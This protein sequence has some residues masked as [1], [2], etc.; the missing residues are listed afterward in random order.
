MKPM[1]RAH[2]KDILYP[3]YDGNSTCQNENLFPLK[4]PFPSNTS[5]F[6][7]LS[8]HP[9]ASERLLRALILLPTS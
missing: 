2:A 6:A 8:V 9:M 3:T 7:A 4:F 1:H 5:S